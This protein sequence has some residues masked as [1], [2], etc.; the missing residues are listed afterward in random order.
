MFIFYQLTFPVWLNADVLSGP[1]A[2]SHPSGRDPVDPDRFLSLCSGREPGRTL[3]LGWTTLSA[4]L[5]A[6]KGPAYTK[7]SLDQMAKLLEKV[8]QRSNV[9]LE[10][11][12]LH[13]MV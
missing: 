12:P 1:G 5:Q 3:S 7:E 4:R 6:E 11:L 13:D 10:V 2:D 8:R 9:S